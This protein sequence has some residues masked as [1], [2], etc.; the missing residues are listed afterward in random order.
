MVPLVVGFAAE[1]GDDNATAAEHAAAKAR[2]KGAALLVFNE[3][4]EHKG[5]GDVP[6]SVRILD[7]TGTEVAAASGSKLAVAHA[8]LDAI[9]E[10]QGRPD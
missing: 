8:V 7:A 2:R 5:F 1:T 10:R 4:G 9:S 6:N 3:V